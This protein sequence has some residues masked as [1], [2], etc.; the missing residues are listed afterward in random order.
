MLR[1]TLAEN[2]NIQTVLMIAS[3]HC[4]SL[5]G[6]IPNDCKSARFQVGATLPVVEVG[7][8]LITFV[9]SLFVSSSC[10]MPA[11]GILPHS[12]SRFQNN[13]PLYL[14]P[15]LK[16]KGRLLESPLR[17]NKVVKQCFIKDAQRKENIAKPNTVR[18]VERGSQLE[19]N[20]HDFI[21]LFSVFCFSVVGS[22]VHLFQ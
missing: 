1:N 4:C 18:G 22:R 17:K 7:T 15:M 14:N 11:G 2:V 10:V 16:A 12:S 8:F 9:A 6:A 21:L 13:S 5:G 3:L 20:H 19:E